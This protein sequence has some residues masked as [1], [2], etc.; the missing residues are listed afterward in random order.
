MKSKLPVQKGPIHCDMPTMK[1]MKRSE[2]NS[3]DAMHDKMRA[4]GKKMT[5][6]TPKK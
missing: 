1:N 2:M 6:H 3:E 5:L 4:D